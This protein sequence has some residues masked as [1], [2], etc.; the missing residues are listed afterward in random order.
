MSVTEQ[1]HLRNAIHQLEAKFYE[2]P[3][4]TISLMPHIEYYLNWGPSSESSVSCLYLDNSRDES[5]QLV[6]CDYKTFLC[7]LSNIDKLHKRAKE[8]HKYREQEARL[9]VAQINIAIEKLT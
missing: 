8:L 1:D 6:E 5:L 7:V 4:C 9:L 2:L 3:A